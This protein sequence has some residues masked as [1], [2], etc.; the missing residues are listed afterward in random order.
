MKKLNRKEMPAGWR[1]QTGLNPDFFASIKRWMR[2]RGDQ[3]AQL[4]SVRHAYQ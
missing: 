4:L 1:I 3:V 2:E